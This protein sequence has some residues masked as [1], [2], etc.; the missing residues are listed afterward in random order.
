MVYIFL[1]LTSIPCW[2]EFV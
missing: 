1:C 2:M